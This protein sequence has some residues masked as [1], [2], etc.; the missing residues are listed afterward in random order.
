MPGTTLGVRVEHLPNPFVVFDLRLNH[1]LQRPRLAPVPAGDP[2]VAVDSEVIAHA[3]ESGVWPQAS[4]RGLHR[5]TTLLTAGKRRDADWRS[6]TTSAT[7]SGGMSRAMRNPCADSR[8]ARRRIASSSGHSIPPAMT[9]RPR[10]CARSRGLPR[11]PQVRFDQ[12]VLVDAGDE[13]AVDLEGAQ[14]QFLEPYQ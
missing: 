13:R 2:G 12:A 8:P 14:R 11:L 3:S 1:R 9:C 7:W 4:G 6:G 10:A 5:A